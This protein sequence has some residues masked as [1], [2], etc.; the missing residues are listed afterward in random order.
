MRDLMHVV[1]RPKFLY[2]GGFTSEITP[3]RRNSKYGVAWARSGGGWAICV[4]RFWACKMP[5]TDAMSKAL[6]LEATV[7]KLTKTQN[8]LF[9]HIH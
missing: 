2:A 1:V 8:E 6:E 3:A 7:R 9:E 5:R 4:W